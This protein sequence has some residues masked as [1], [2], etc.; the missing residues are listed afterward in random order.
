MFAGVVTWLGILEWK[1]G[2]KNTEWRTYVNQEHGYSIEYPDDWYIREENNALFI[3]SIDKPIGAIID[4]TAKE[5]GTF[6]RGYNVSIIAYENLGNLSLEE[7]INSVFMEELVDITETRIN[8]LRVLEAHEVNSII[9]FL[10]HYFLEHNGFIYE[11]RCRDEYS[12]LEDVAK[13][14]IHTL[15]FEK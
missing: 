8:K 2:E 11:I 6:V 9:T 10:P 12:G 14:I 5:N 1:K 13:S 15:R 3:D 4:I 7:Y